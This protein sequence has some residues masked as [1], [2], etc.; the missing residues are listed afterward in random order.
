ME[1]EMDFRWIYASTDGRISRKTWW[2]SALIL[3]V[4]S[5]VV[6]WVIFPLIGLGMPDVVALMNAQ[7]DPRQV[8]NLI[9]SGMQNA[10]WGS[11]VLFLLTAYP[12]YC[13][14]VKR[15]HDKNNRGVDVLVYFAATAVLLLIQAVGLGYSVQEIPGFPA[16]V[17]M[18]TMLFSGL[19]FLIGVF[20][21][22]MFVVLGFLR[23]TIGPNDYGADPVEGAA[24]ARA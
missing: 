21:I 22:Y 19:G 6:S 16:P 24:S 5:M 7:S 17:P 1:D 15:R 13:I 12:A 11:L 14:S 23:G 2:I 8:A 10:A 20:G 4:V 9:T 3:G 18:P